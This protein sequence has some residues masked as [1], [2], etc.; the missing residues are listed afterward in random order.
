MRI[1]ASGVIESA[2]HTKLAAFIAARTAK[3]GLPP[4]LTIMFDSPGGNIAGGLA[5]GRFIRSRGYNTALEKDVEEELGGDA[6]GASTPMRRVATNTMCPSACS[7]AFF[8]GLAR[9]ITPEARLGVHQ[10]YSATGNNIGDGATQVTMTMLALYLE[11]MGVGRR[12]LDLAT[13]AGPTGMFWVP[14]LLR[15][16]LKIDNTRPI[17]SDWQID[18][19]VPSLKVSQAVG[20]STDLVLAMKNSGRRVSLTVIAILAKEVPGV[21]RQSRFPVGERLEIEFKGQGSRRWQLLHGSV[22]KY[23]ETAALCLGASFQCHALTLRSC[24]DRGSWEITDNFSNA[25]R[26]VSIS[27][28]FIDDQVIRWCGASAQ[29]RAMKPKSLAFGRSD[30]LETFATECATAL[31]STPPMA[32]VKSPPDCSDINWCEATIKEL[33]SAFLGSLRNNGNVYALF[34][35][36]P[37]QTEWVPMY[38]GKSARTYLRSRITNHLIG[39]SKFLSAFPRGQYW[40]GSD[41]HDF[42]QEASGCGHRRPPELD[43]SR[44]SRR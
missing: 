44:N 19:G 32:I 5:L 9:E 42:S 12:I 13:S 28:P 6:F 27:T 30:E 3:D 26:D 21:D 22:Y 24:R 35:R 7:L 34:L 16:E 39:K 18:H 43:P 11:E 37:D 31:L 8:G 36:G 29:D 14:D 15:R 38:V 23:Q 4:Q 17:L 40:I 1:L 33:N 25:I 10:F 41:T 20:P 2:S